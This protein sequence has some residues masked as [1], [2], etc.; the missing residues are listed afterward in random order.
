MPEYFFAFYGEG[1]ADYEFLLKVIERY[2]KQ[3]LP[4]VDFV[5]DPVYHLEGASEQERLNK[6]AQDYAGLHFIIVHLDADGSTEEKALKH[7]FPT[8]YEA[9]Q[10]IPIIPIKETEA[11]LLADYEAF[12]QVVGTKLS[13][14]EL[15]FPPQ[16]HQVESINEPKEV[17][18]QAISR[19]RSRRKRIELDEIYQA[20]GETVSLN[21]LKKVPAFQNFHTRIIKILIGLGFR[22]LE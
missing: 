3:L 16:V 19:S 13:A 14:Q 15:E 12:K 5:S 18:K 1:K 2:L 20:M 11:W 17:L 8:D 10:L 6:L 22:D 4:H 21:H 7:R 9:K